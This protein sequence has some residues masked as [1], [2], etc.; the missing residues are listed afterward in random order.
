MSGSFDFKGTG[1]DFCRRVTQSR[2]EMCQVR[3]AAACAYSYRHVPHPNHLQPSGSI[4]QL[5]LSSLNG[6]CRFIPNRGL[7]VF[8]VPYLAAPSSRSR[9]FAVP[10]A[11]AVKLL[12]NIDPHHF[13]DVTRVTGTFAKYTLAP[14]GASLEANHITNQGGIMLPEGESRVKKVPFRR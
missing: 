12:H 14:T 11:A 1:R 7:L 4:A 9:A 13:T 6:R 10:P 2:H 3:F 5:K 8:A